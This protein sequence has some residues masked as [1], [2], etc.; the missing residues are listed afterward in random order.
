MSHIRKLGEPRVEEEPVQETPKIYQMGVTVP[1]TSDTS[2]QTVDTQMINEVKEITKTVDTLKDNEEL[3]KELGITLPD[4]SIT[5]SMSTANTMADLMLDAIALKAKFGKKAKGD[6]SDVYNMLPNRLKDIDIIVAAKEIEAKTSKLTASERKL[7]IKL[8]KIYRLREETWNQPIEKTVEKLKKELPVEP[9]KEIDDKVNAVTDSY[10]HI[11][12]EPPGKLL[13]DE[14]KVTKII[15]MTSLK[16]RV[17]ACASVAELNKEVT[18]IES[19]YDN[20]EGGDTHKAAEIINK[21]KAYL[22]SALNSPIDASV[23]ENVKIDVPEQPSST[24]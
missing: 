15:T 12:E 6:P 9:I 8:A 4:L 20:V 23:F 21:H 22:E 19:E 5:N 10:T 14:D 18:A 2:E 3:L 17:L 11:E 24:I 1:V 13:V 16:N 7:I